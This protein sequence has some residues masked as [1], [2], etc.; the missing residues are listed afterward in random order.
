MSAPEGWALLTLASQFLCVF[1][2]ATLNQTHAKGNSWKH[3][4][5]LV[6]L[7]W[8]KP[9]IANSANSVGILNLA[10]VCEGEIRTEGTKSLH[11][12][13]LTPQL[14]LIIKVYKSPLLS[15]RHVPAWASPPPCVSCG[16]V[17]ATETQEWKSGLCKFEVETVSVHAGMFTSPFPGHGDWQRSGL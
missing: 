2:R 8:Y 4:F 6:C 5:S 1:L 12:C 7:F 15:S 11:P 16:P 9:A 17:L 14:L 3:T 10:C 13:G